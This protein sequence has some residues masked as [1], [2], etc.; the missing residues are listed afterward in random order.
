MSNS[1]DIRP[2]FRDDLTRTFISIYFAFKSG[3]GKNADAQF[4][5]G[6]ISALASFSLAVGV[7]PSAFLSPEDAQRVQE[8]RS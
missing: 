6:F 8:E 2:W 5:A 4:R 3:Q 7:D 1:K